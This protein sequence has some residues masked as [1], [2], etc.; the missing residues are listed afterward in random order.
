MAA[1]GPGQSLVFIGFMGAGKSTAAREVAAVLGVA[2]VD[3]DDLVEAR[4]G[5]PIAEHF[6]AHG[7][8]AFRAEEG[9]TDGDNEPYHG[10]L[11][12]DTMWTHGTA[13]GLPHALIEVRQD[14]I[15]D[16]A[17][18][19]RMTGIVT[20]ALRRALAQAGLPG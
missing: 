19:A 6:A 20:R 2:A 16:E 5:M 8:E 18:I 13:R 1:L 7:E 14:L 15:A 4:I 10:A 17:G 11:E 12:G 9:F 3:T